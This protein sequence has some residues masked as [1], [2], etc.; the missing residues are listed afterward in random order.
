M[1]DFKTF[2]ESLLASRCR[3]NKTTIEML[4]ND[5]NISQFKRAFTSKG[6]NPEI[7]YEYYEILG[8]STANKIISWYLVS[9]FENNFHEVEGK[10]S[11]ISILT[12]LILN[13]ISKTSFEKISK[14]LNFDKY[15]LA[16]NNEKNNKTFD[17]KY[18]N[19]Y[20]DVFEAFVGCLE[21]LIN[22]NLKE[23][24]GYG[25]CYNF[26]KSVFDEY[27]DSDFS[28]FTYEDLYDPKSRLGMEIDKFSTLVKLKEKKEDYKV[29]YE[30]IDTTTNTIY[31][32]DKFTGEDALQKA[33][34]NLFD[35]KYFDVLHNKLDKIVQEKKD[36]RVSRV[37]EKNMLEYTT[38]VY[39][40]EDLKT[41]FLQILKFLK[42]DRKHSKMF[43]TNENLIKLRSA[44]TS[45]EIDKKN[46]YLLYSLLGD[47]TINKI[48]VSYFSTRFSS[49]LN[50]SVSF[51]SRIKQHF[52]STKTIQRLY[53]NNE[54]KE[55]IFLEIKKFIRITPEEYNMAI[56][57]TEDTTY[58]R[59]FESLIG[60]L[61]RIIDIETKMKIGYNVCYTFFKKYL[62]LL[63]DK[64]IDEVKYD[65]KSVLNKQY[66]K[67]SDIL[68]QLKDSSKYEKIEKKITSLMRLPGYNSVTSEQKVYSVHYILRRGNSV[69]T[70]PIFTD[71]IKKRA[72]QNAADYV[73][74]NNLLRQI[75][76]N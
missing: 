31:V 12:R 66:E 28:N 54:D 52:S 59:Y 75:S 72:E 49:E 34:Q 48:I 73:L 40:D 61:E 63:D 57:N 71:Y 6:Y 24:L 39:T 56:V 5:E 44:L 43:V 20:E 62:N 55:N 41:F 74:K 67:S 29:S 50:K 22:K 19:I 13:T 47:K 37:K 45:N 51:M 35:K 26:I 18:I 65:A 17:N 15:I 4:T 3:L 2:M 53:E 46:N 64:I 42:I 70:T 27:K 14:S 23:G 36:A 7:N 21:Y 11:N 68:L 76:Q 32:S 33:S 1:T 25:I 8:D 16:T 38:N 69:I 60:C 9:R 58:Q 10:M 30:L